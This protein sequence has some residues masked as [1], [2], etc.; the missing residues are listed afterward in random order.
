VFFEV[1]H[2]RLFLTFFINDEFYAFHKN[3]PPFVTKLNHYLRQF[4]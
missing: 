3:G 1:Y 2:N 4:K